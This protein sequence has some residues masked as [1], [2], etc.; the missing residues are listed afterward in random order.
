MYVYSHALFISIAIPVRSRMEPEIHLTTDNL[1]SLWCPFE[2]GIAS[3]R[4]DPYH[5]VWF[6]DDMESMNQIS[7]TFNDS[8]TEDLSCSAE[9][10]CALRIRDC[11]TSDCSI[12]VYPTP[13]FRPSFKVMKVGKFRSSLLI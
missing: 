11:N 6:I 1:F 5:Y 8:I 2:L 7:Q 10:S 9:Y 13:S 4:L 12:S 3:D